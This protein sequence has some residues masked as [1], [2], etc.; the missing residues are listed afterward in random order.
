MTKPH[1]VTC[2]KKVYTF[3]DLSK[4]YVPVCS[5]TRVDTKLIR[6]VNK[7]HFYF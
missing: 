5:A 1:S 6:A 4:Q 3:H 2:L 7:Y